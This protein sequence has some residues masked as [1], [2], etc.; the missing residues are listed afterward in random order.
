MGELVKESGMV[1]KTNDINFKIKQENITFWRKFVKIAKGGDVLLSNVAPES[2]EVLWTS[3][4]GKEII[5]KVSGTYHFVDRTGR[6]YSM[7]SSL[8]MLKEM[9]RQSC[10]TDIIRELRMRNIVF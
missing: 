5:T 10:R 9:L 7:G 3:N 1:S 8:L 4:D 6:P 2:S